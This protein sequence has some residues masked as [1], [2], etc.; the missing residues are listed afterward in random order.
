MTGH[1]ELRRQDSLQAGYAALDV[2]G[3][4]TR[5]A[6]EVVVVHTARW[7]VAGLATGEGG[8]A[9]FAGLHPALE[10]AVDRRE[11]DS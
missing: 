2:E 1:R 3:P 7:L 4:L 6:Q 8:L 9:Q 5:R 11:P 10:R